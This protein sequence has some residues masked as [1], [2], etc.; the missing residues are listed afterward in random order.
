MGRH[1]TGLDSGG[2]FFR[3]VGGRREKWRNDEELRP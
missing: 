2:L 1:R 3:V